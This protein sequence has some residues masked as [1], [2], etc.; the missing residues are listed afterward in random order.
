MLKYLLAQ[1]KDSKGIYVDG[2][3]Y[4]FVGGSTYDYKIYKPSYVRYKISKH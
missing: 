4:T 2:K 3:S 1:I